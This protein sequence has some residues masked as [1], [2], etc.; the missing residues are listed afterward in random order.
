LAAGNASRRFARREAMAM[1]QRALDL[2]NRLPETDRVET[3]TATLETQALM[4]AVSFDTLAPAV[5]SYEAMAL[6]A[7]EHGLIG[8]EVRALIGMAYPLHW[9]DSMRCFEVAEKALQLSLM[10]P[11]MLL[12]AGARTTCYYWRLWAGGWD[13][14]DFKEI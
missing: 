1:L 8:V 3:E 4:W 5:E 6:R 13:H 10:Q 14:R 12:R 9:F 11:D 7:R 2:S